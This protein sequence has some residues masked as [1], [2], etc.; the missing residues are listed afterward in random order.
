MKTLPLIIFSLMML[1]TACREATDPLLAQLNSEIALRDHYKAEKEKRVERLERELAAP[2]LPPEKRMFL[3][4]DLFNEYLTYQVDS[5]L[6]V[7]G[8]QRSFAREAGRKDWEHLSNIH[9]IMLLSSAGYFVDLERQLSELPAD[10]MSP[11]LKLEYFKAAESVFNHLAD[12][13]SDT[14][15]AARY[16]A[17]GSRYQDS[18]LSLLP[19]VSLEH[20]YRKG[21]RLWDINRPDSAIAELSRVITGVAPDQR[22][23]AQVAYGLS[24]LYGFKG[25][26][27]K[28]REFLI[29]AAISDIKAQLKEGVALQELALFLRE[30]GADKSLSNHYLTLSMEDAGFY[31]NK[32]RLLQ[33]AYKYPAIVTQYESQL[34]EANHRHEMALAVIAILVAVL[35]GAICFLIVTLRRARRE[36]ARLVEADSERKAAFSRLASVNEQLAASNGHLREQTGLR[37][38]CIALFAE[39][40]AAYINKLNQ[41]HLTVSHK[42]KAGLTD[43]LLRQVSTQS[44]MSEAE[45]RNF[46]TSFDAAFLRAF[47]DFVESVNRDLKP[48][49]RF[50]LPDGAS[51]NLDLRILALMRI[52]VTDSS[53]I[54]TILNCSTQTIYN[55]RSRLRARALRQPGSWEVV[56]QA[57]QG[58]GK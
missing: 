15:F 12:F 10:E 55:H 20:H 40:T 46:F 19:P 16:W 5:A 23:Y 21:N 30:T 8:R 49:F 17:E 48:E 24:C 32:L 13:L 22:L 25:D 4:D 11:E 18:I 6:S 26:K 56:A 43:E 51:L 45:A 42:I 1:L 37:E 44:K 53:R 2:S 38:K 50:D 3:Y 39:I 35:C 29:R 54:A 33:S 52:G 28:R 7:V 41:F 34:E 47:P 14:G 58:L 31:G 27:A 9:E 36:H 57:R